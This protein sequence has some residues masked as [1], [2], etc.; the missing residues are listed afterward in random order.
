MQNIISLLKNDIFYFF[1]LKTHTQQTSAK[2]PLIK[3]VNAF[4]ILYPIE[5]RD[6][7]EFPHTLISYSTEH[8]SIL[9]M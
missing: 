1:V 2:N 3:D 7:V 5:Q 4:S 6:T 9:G 8:F